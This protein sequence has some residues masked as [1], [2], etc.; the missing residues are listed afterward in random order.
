MK[1]ERDLKMESHGCSHMSSCLCSH[2]REEK[3]GKGIYLFQEES[4]FSRW[5][6]LEIQSAKKTM[7]I[8]KILKMYMLQL[9]LLILNIMAV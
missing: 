6:R 1:D 2:A 3:I 9:D 7:V 8:A 4:F 5:P